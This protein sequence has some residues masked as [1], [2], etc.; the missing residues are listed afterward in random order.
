MCWRSAQLHML[1]VQSLVGTDSIGVELEEKVV[2][3]LASA[4]FPLPIL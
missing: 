2:D 4:S 3:N 1:A